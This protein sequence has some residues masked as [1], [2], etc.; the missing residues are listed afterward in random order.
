ME[1]SGERAGGVV[2]ASKVFPWR[3]IY[4]Q[5]GGESQDDAASR[6]FPR[7]QHIYSRGDGRESDELTCLIGTVMS[8]VCLLTKDV[9]LW[10]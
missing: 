1:A 5:G 6:S 9:T 2:F 8:L 10:L 3:D 7:I 4:T